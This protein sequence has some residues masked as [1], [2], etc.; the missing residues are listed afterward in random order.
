MPHA[1]LVRQAYPIP[2]GHVRVTRLPKNLGS[3]ASLH[4]SSDAT[5]LPAA[6]AATP[7]HDCPSGVVRRL[8]RSLGGL[9]NVPADLTGQL[10]ALADRLTP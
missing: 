3:I 1:L 8:A 5:R 10:T 7:N 9:P 6:I 2:S 4:L